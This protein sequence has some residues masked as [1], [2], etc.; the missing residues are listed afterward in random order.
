[1]KVTLRAARI[2]SGFTIDEAASRIGVSKWTLMNYEHGKSYPDIP[3]LKN[4]E[5]VYGVAY[6]D[7]IFP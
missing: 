1:M 3:I 4:I 7:I 2:N 6:S 5:S